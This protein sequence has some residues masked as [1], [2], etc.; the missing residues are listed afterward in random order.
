MF[1]WFGRADRDKTSPERRPLRNQ[2]YD[3][4][5]GDEL[6]RTRSILVRRE[7]DNTLAN[8]IVAKL[9]FLH[10]VN[11]QLQICI[12]IES[13]GGN[14]VAC[15]AICDTIKFVSCPVATHCPTHAGG[16]A[17]LLLAAGEPGKRSISSEAS[18][19]FSPLSNDGEPSD[20]FNRICDEVEHKFAELTGQSHER[21]RD[22]MESFARFDANAAKD[23]GLVD[24]VFT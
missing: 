9:L 11:A 24:F 4:L 1:S 19:A 23:Y 21:I 22:D 3:Q 12:D 13:N 5:E 15:F 16:I 14:V 8:E 10:S 20:N 6:R 7:I 2:I 18:I 17:A